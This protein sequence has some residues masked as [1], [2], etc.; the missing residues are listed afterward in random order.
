MECS[1]DRIN[2]FWTKYGMIAWVFYKK[3]EPN[4]MRAPCFLE[5]GRFF[6]KILELEQCSFYR[7]PVFLQNMGMRAVF[8]S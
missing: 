3:I 6:D 4:D 2:A 7:T 1:F 5:D 8:F